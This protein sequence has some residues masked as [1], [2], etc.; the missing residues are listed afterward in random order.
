MFKVRP[1]S[2]DI[3]ADL[4][5]YEIYQEQCNKVKQKVYKVVV[6]GDKKCGKTSILKKLTGG[7]F[8]GFYIPTTGTDYLFKNVQLENQCINFQLWDVGGDEK[9]SPAIKYYLRNAIGAIIVFDATALQS[10]DGV[11]EWKDIL[12]RIARLPDGSKVPCVL[13]ANKCESVG[14]KGVVTNPNQMDK[15]V[16]K[17]GI[18]YWFEVS[19]RDNIGIGRALL[20]LGEE[21]VKKNRLFHYI[22]DEPID[23]HQDKFILS[24]KIPVEKPK[25]C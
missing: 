25:K 17:N 7:T 8:R 15:Y 13:L 21:M 16:D 3:L 4:I 12:D 11:S 18:S 20:K 6:I 19:A 2:P 22:E 5:G 1:T 23:I 24:Q 14:K 9:Y 10:I